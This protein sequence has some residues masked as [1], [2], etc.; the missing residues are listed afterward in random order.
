TRIIVC[1][2]SYDHDHADSQNAENAVYYIFNIKQPFE[3][4]LY[5]RVENKETGCFSIAELLL[6]VEERVYAFPPLSSEFCETD[7]ENDGSTTVDLTVM[8]NAIIGTQIV[9]GLGV[10]YYRSNGT[11]IGDPSN[12]VVSEGE[13]IIA[14]VYNEDDVTMLCTA[15]VE[16]VI[17]LKDAPV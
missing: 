16:I 6:K 15:T 2:D 10:R 7:Y 12:A 4:T 11:P 17:S 14:E 5:V 8:D 13:V 1:I 3:Q 9:Q